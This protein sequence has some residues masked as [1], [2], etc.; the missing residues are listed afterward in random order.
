MAACPVCLQRCLMPACSAAHPLPAVVLSDCPCLLK[1]A[2]ALVQISLVAPGMGR[3]FNTQCGRCLH[4]FVLCQ[5]LVH[6]VAL[7]SCLLRVRLRWQLCSRT[8]LKA[9]PVPWVRELLTGRLL[10][11]HCWPLRG[12]VACCVQESRLQRSQVYDCPPGANFDGS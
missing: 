7:S 5:V 2:L 4:H 6:G 9:L 10:L 12:P 3:M 1:P 8:R 11:R